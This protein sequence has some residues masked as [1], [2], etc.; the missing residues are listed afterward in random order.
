LAVSGFH[1]ETAFLGGG[2]WRDEAAKDFGK[3][4]GWMLHIA[5][6]ERKY[7]EGD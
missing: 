6:D 2:G 3:E 1:R 5:L 7:D 4:S